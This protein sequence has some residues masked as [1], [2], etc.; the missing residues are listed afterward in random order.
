M[1]IGTWAARAPDRPAVVMG[2]TGEVRTY[3]EVQAGSIRLARLLRA[4]GLQTGDHVAVM[5]ENH[6]TFFE[7]AWAALRSG[8]Y[9]TPVNSHLTAGEA[10]Y[11]VNDCQAKVLITSTALREVA[12]ALAPLAPGLVHRLMVTGSGLGRA[13]PGFDPYE[14]ARDQWPADPLDEEP[15]GTTMLYSSGTTGRPKGIWFP[16]PTGELGEASEPVIQL[17]G[18]AFGFREGMVYLSPAPLYHSAPLRGS[19]CAQCYGGTVVV[20][21]RFDAA[22]ALRLIERERVTHSQWVPTMF[23]RMLDLPEEERLRWDLS[24]HERAVHAAAPCPVAVKERMIAWWGPIIDEYYSGTETIGAT[25]ITSAEWL[26]HKGSVGR[27]RPGVHLHICDEASREVDAGTA[28][29]VFFENPAAGFRY[30]GD[31]EKTASVRHPDHPDWR[32]LGDVGYVDD[33]GYLYLTDRRAFTI[34]AGGVNI[35]PQEVEEVLVAHG[36]VADAAVFGV[37]SQ[38]MGEEVKAVVEPT[39]WADAGADLA[40][41]LRTHCEKCL[42]RFKVPRSFDFV[43]ALPRSETGKLYKEALRQPYWQGH[44][45]RIL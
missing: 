20:M 36:K 10:A 16:L 13:A 42:A 44:A 3:A 28:G 25:V 5:L 27:A 2:A 32:T 24:S 38:E 40:A 6:P 31:P 7:V 23:S 4:N 14:E 33:G 30:F 43:R 45:S 11:L 41:E 34:I 1:Q 15:R 9:L 37:P 8:L 26:E 39:R 12:S 21:E 22:V 17:S 29:T 19:L 35:Y 18:G